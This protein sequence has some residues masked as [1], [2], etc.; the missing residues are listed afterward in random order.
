MIIL[1]LLTAVALFLLLKVKRGRHESEAAD[2]EECRQGM[3]PPPRREEV[4]SAPAA[5]QVRARYKKVLRLAPVRR[6]HQEKSDTSLDIRDSCAGRLDDE[7]VA[8]LRELYIRA[9]YQGY[10]TK[11]EAR[12]A[13]ELYQRIKKSAAP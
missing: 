12:R 4:P 9:R 10:A 11:T 2:V 5:A 1:L 8:E 3:V 7:A 6:R 13:K